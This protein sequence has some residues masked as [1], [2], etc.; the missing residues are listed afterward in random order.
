MSSGG[1]N[2]G[3]A[4]GGGGKPVYWEEVL[5]GGVNGVEE[6]MYFYSFIFFIAVHLAGQML[7][8][9]EEQ[10][11]LLKMRMCK[12]ITE[13]MKLRQMLTLQNMLFDQDRNQNF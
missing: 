4:W 6:T 10:H 11:R 13:T 12:Q 9:N 3:I 2:L 7:L 5:P 8:R 1:N